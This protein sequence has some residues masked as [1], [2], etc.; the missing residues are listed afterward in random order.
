[1]IQY[2]LGRRSSVKTK[3][4][5]RANPYFGFAISPLKTEDFR[6]RLFYK[7]SVRLPSFNEMYYS[8]IG[9]L[10]LNPEDAHQINIGA[11]YSFKQKKL[12]KDLTFRID[13]YQNF[14]QNKIVSIPTKDLFVWSI[15]NVDKV[16]IFGLDVQVSS[17]LKLAKKTTL[18]LSGN[19]SFQNALNK[20]DK[21]H[22]TY[23]HQIAYIP[24]HQVNTQ[25]GISSFGAFINWSS[26]F[27]GARFHLNENNDFNRLNS[28]WNN[29]LILGYEHKLKTKHRL[30]CTFTIGNIAN[31]RYEVVRSF[32]MLGRN[33]KIKLI[34]A[35]Q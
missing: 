31:A 1:M 19:Y 7:N 14:V 4:F 24:K 21:N 15:Q 34:Y 13:A 30:K 10:D 28:F 27:T 26:S 16:S 23:N 22:I 17:I 20:T 35:F 33:Y 29:D 32:P 6:L 18:N 12:L 5:F 2:I 25:L 9:N 11:T 8:Q 3:D